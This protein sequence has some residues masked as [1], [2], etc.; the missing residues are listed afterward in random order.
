MASRAPVS[1]TNAYERRGKPIDPS[2]GDVCLVTGASGFIGGHVVER[3]VREGYPVRCLVRGSSDTSLLQAFGVEL[4]SGD[5]ADPAALRA[6]AQGCRFVVHCGALVS[7]WGTAREIERVN[8]EGTRHLLEAASAAGVERFVHLSSTDVYSHPGSPGV[9]EEQRP[10]RFGNWYSHTK[11]LAEAEVRRIERERKLP[12]VILRPAT[13]Y[14]PRS[15]HVIGE[16]GRALAAGQMLLVDGGRHVA[17]LC[18]V[19]NLVDAVLLA[20]QHEQ[21]PGQTFNIADGSRVTWKEFTDALAR[22]LGC[23]P[24]RFNAPYWL[25]NALGVALEC[26]YR[27]L[28]ALTGLRTAPLLS[29]QAVQLLGTDQDFDTTKARAVLGWAPR[30]DYSTGLTATLGWLRASLALPPPRDGHFT[31]LEASATNAV[32]AADDRR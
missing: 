11:W 8:V 30:V 14:G 13:V 6:A 24:A 7:D 15:P 31:S 32:V 19:D 5:L 23:K 10:A 16:I 12:A 2:A 28:R 17:G 25:V 9:G 29:R 21:A 4:A 27:C 22:G 18:Y 3:L 20:L 1:E 26:G